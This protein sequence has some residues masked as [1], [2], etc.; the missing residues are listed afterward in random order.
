MDGTRVNL[1]GGWTIIWGAISGALGGVGGAL[2]VFGTLVV[3][4]GFASWLW[5][6]RRGTGGDRAIPGCCGRCSSGPCW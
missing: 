6:K 1:A 5:Q 2:T 3:V 4:V